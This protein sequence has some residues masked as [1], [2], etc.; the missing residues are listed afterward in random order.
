ML[1]LKQ[2][3]YIC[4]SQD[5]DVD[6]AVD[7]GHTERRVGIPSDSI[8][9][10]GIA[11]PLEPALGV[12]RQAGI[13]VLVLAASC[14][15][16][17]LIFSL[18]RISTSE[19]E[20]GQGCTVTP[21]LQWLCILVFVMIIWEE[22][23]QSFELV[24]LLIT[25]P[26]EKQSS[27][28][29]DSSRSSEDA[30]DSSSAWNRK[31]FST[32][33]SEDEVEDSPESSSR[34]GSDAREISRPRASDEDEHG[35]WNLIVDGGCVCCDGWQACNGFGTAAF[36]S[37]KEVLYRRQF[38]GFDVLTIPRTWKF[39]MFCYVVVPKISLELALVFVGSAYI[40][41]ARSDQEAIASVVA[42]NFISTV[43]EI[44]LH[45]L[46]P[47]GTLRA[48][49]QSPPLVYKTESRLRTLWVFLRTEGRM[50]VDALLVTAIT[51]ILFLRARLL[52]DCGAQ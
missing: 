27:A 17:F 40:A 28:R 36:R 51:H 41:V 4:V 26:T 11:A 12:F 49:D 3:G 24:E 9:G 31:K 47:T 50:W 23:S 7:D 30:Q 1:Q 37:D 33:Q 14:F 34:A 42:V 2:F 39:I 20:E 18:Y 46:F 5:E 48:L 38:D 43:D 35:C 19:L 6:E 8:F 25:V 45:C 32:R 15:Q 16:G 52:G 10:L 44:F 22:V 21:Y 13:A 29:T